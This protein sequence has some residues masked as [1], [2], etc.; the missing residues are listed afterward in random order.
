MEAPFT[1]EELEILRGKYPALAKTLNTSDTY[2]K[3]IAN[4]Y[5]VVKSS[6]SK[7]C[8]KK[9]KETVEFFTPK[10]AMK[11]NKNEEHRIDTE[12]LP[13]NKFVLCVNKLSLS[14]Y[15]KSREAL[16]QSN[17]YD[18]FVFINPEKKDYEEWETYLEID[19][20]TYFMLYNNLCDKYRK[21]IVTPM[22]LNYKKTLK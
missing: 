12:P 3:Q 8:Y 4:G 13:K 2:L 18:F 20:E 19:E 1:K 22:Y 11:D 16:I 15:K 21:N 9:L 17:C 10:T 5:R 7:K 14:L 6:K